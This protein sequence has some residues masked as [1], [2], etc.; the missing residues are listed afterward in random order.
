MAVDRRHPYHLEI[1]QH[2]KFL[3][4]AE[5]LSRALKVKFEDPEVGPSDLSTSITLYYAALNSIEPDTAENLERRQPLLIELAFLLD[6]RWK[7]THDPKDGEEADE[8][9]LMQS[10]NYSIIPYFGKGQH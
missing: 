1:L 2:T 7:M 9:E 3:Q 10:Q 6:Q 5:R 4:R 8:I